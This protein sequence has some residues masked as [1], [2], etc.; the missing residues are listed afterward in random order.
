ML[1][2]NEKQKEFVDILLEE[3]EPVS[4]MA[5]QSRL[6]S[7]KR[8]IYNIANKVNDELIYH[9]IDPIYN[10]RGKGY[11]FTEEQKKQIYRQYLPG[12]AIGRT[13]RVSY[14]ACW[15]LY[16]EK[17]I[18]LEDIIERL[19]VSRNSVFNDLKRV[20]DIYDLYNIRLEFDIKKGYTT[21][22]TT[23]NFHS[24][25]MNYLSQLLVNVEYYY[26]HF[27]DTSQTSLYFG[28][29]YKI[30]EELGHGE[31][32]RNLLVI[33]CLASLMHDRQDEFSF[34]LMELKDLIETKEFA[35][36]DKYF[37]D[38]K[39]LERLYLTIYLLGSK[40]SRTFAMEEDEDNIRL[41]QM[42]ESMVEEFEQI[43]MAGLLDRTQ[44]INSLYMHFKLTLYYYKLSIH[45]ANPLKKQVKENYPDLYEVVR[46]VCDKFREIAPFPISDGEIIYITMHFGGHLKQGP[47]RFYRKVWVLVVC[48]S[49]IATSALL[50]R[51]IESLYSNVTVVATMAADHIEEYEGNID[52]IVSTVDISTQLPWVKVSTILTN[53][54]KSRIAS[55]MMLNF[56]TY[57]VDERRMNGLFEVLEKYVPPHKMEQ[58][59]QDVYQ[60]LN[61]GNAIVKIADHE[62]ELRIYDVLGT[63]DIL[64]LDE[65]IDWKE[66][67][68]R[69]SESLV[70]KKAVEE[71]YIDSM[72]SLVEKYG[73]YI[74]LQ[75]RV[76]VAHGKPEEGANA[77]GLS[78]LVNRTDILFEGE[79]TVRYLFVLSDPSAHEHFRL[80]RDIMLFARN[81]ELLD[82]LG[83]AQ[84]P[85]DVLREIINYMINEE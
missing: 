10:K 26:I 79:V 14:L 77:L 63:G 54:D 23:M 43:S 52:F 29:L 15:L 28:R 45:I 41:L 78:L 73:S 39:V 42:A 7:S 25:L 30:S 66:A 13:D 19:Q 47:E 74:V 53:D 11:Y 81:R 12:G 57:Q 80:V 83:K 22:G 82:V 20:K 70:Q 31:D 56:E 32:E 44:L 55:M 40:A 2:F 76:A 67:I 71:R 3:Q 49:G 64:L 18:H 27:I 62:E 58:M 50:S 61:S 38:F 9:S 69:T 51:E 72:I 17:I 1:M 16:P 59:K 36:I 33:A 6:K 65:S 75:N 85:E 48:P 60:Y 84:L 37:Q 34:S 46:T 8:T 21:L 68:T 35:L 4:N 5:M 24:L